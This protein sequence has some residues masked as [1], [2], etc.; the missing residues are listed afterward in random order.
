MDPSQFT[1]DAPGELTEIPVAGWAYIPDP[2]PPPLSITPQVLRL[3]SEADRAVGELEGAGHIIPNP[4]LFIGPF[5]RREAVYSS[6]IEGTVTSFDDLGLFEV[7]G[8]RAEEDTQE[9]GNYV[10]ATRHGL[11]QLDK[12]PPS[13]RLIREVHNVLLEHVRG[14]DRH[15]GEFRSIQNYIRGGGLTEKTARYVPPSPEHVL[16]SLYQLEEYMNGQRTYPDLIEL[17]LIHYQFE[18]IHPFEDGNGRIGRVLITL[19][20]ASWNLLANPLLSISSFISAHREEYQDSLL[21][22]SRTGDWNRWFTFFLTAIQEESMNAAQ[23]AKSLLELRETYR[24]KSMAISNSAYDLTI[25]DEL[26][27]SP[28]IT[29]V[30]IRGKCDVSSPTAHSIIKRLM[31]LDILELHDDRQRNRIYVAPSIIAAFE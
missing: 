24:T 29:A 2:L 14:R 20:M 28:W 27:E 17:A 9:V 21:A 5:L 4:E 7:S 16:T 8:I 18:A 31:S 12:I 22:V 19:L 30:M 11:A 6:R 15:P 23:R 13:L 25:I 3:L 1:D 26:I 10:R